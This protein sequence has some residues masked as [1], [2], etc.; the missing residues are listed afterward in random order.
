MPILVV[1]SIKGNHG[2]RSRSDGGLKRRGPTTGGLAPPERCLATKTPSHET[3]SRDPMVA[4]CRQM[5]D[6]HSLRAVYGFSPRSGLDPSFEEER[7]HMCLVFVLAP[8]R[9]PACALRTSRY[10][11][12]S[13]DSLPTIKMSTRRTNY[14]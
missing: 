1:A 7:R 4:A 12:L 13:R 6:A 5:L 9:Q 8:A 14:P 11:A 10:F 2:A 3:L